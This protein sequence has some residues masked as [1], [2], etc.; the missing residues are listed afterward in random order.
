MPV[1]I[2]CAYHTVI[3]TGMRLPACR[4]CY[5]RCTSITSPSKPKS[6]WTTPMQK[7]V[8][9]V[10]APNAWYACCASGCAVHREAQRWFRPPTPSGEN[11]SKYVVSLSHFVLGSVSYGTRSFLR[12]SMALLLYSLVEYSCSVNYFR[13][14]KRA[15]AWES[16]LG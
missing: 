9:H 2:Y 4:L 8:L 5:A 6:L 11:L 10:K 13:A 7:R 3:M 15:V 12:L 14:G 16:K 1:L